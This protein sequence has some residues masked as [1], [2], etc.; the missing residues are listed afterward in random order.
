MQRL[1]APLQEAQRVR[2]QAEPLRV[3]GRVPLRDLPRARTDKLGFASEVLACAW[4]PRYKVVT[5]GPS[6]TTPLPLQGA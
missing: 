4:D 2:R 6:L 5:D 1:D 3:R